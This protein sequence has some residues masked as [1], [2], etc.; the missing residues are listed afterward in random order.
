MDAYLKC[1]SVSDL[2]GRYHRR[3]VEHCLDANN[4]FCFDNPRGIVLHPQ[5]GYCLPVILGSSFMP[6]FCLCYLKANILLGF[7][8]CFFYLVNGLVAWLIQIIFMSFSVF[9]VMTHYFT[10][11]VTYFGCMKKKIV[12]KKKITLLYWNF[13][14]KSTEIPS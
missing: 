4:T 11:Q 10:F 14:S 6:L 7:V 1:L 9:I 2:D 8:S 13:P 3:L 5:Y 12:K